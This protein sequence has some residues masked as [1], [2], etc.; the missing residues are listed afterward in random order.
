M[1]LYQLPHVPFPIKSLQ[2]DAAN[3]EN[4]YSHLFSTGFVPNSIN[5]GTV[6]YLAEYADY[7]LFMKTDRVW[8][9][10][11]MPPLP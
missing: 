8:D 2:L 11:I 5:P 7:Y 1:V 4:F 9:F 3:T 6:I 10:Y